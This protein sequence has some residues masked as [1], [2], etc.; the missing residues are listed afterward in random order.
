ME[1]GFPLFDPNDDAA[2]QEQK[3]REYYEEFSANARKRL[4]AKTVIRPTSVYDVLYPR[5]RELL[6]S[7][8]VPFKTDLEEDAK[9][10]RDR[11]VAKLVTNETD[12]EKISG[13][14]RKSMLARAKI[15]D[16]KNNLM[17][18]GEAFR[19]NLIAKNS[20]KESNIE[21]DSEQVRRA[22]ISKNTPN[23]SKRPQ[24]LIISS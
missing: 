14:F 3:L 13:D 2:R 9:L 23:P 1:D 17:R 19:K 16:D 21:K 7:K 10:I 24:F 8:N 20:P 6:M 12:L 5:T 22:N 18:S 15:Q 11:L 4:L